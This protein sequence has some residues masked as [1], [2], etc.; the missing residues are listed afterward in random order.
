MAD[1][2]GMDLTRVFRPIL[3]RVTVGN[4][5]DSLSS[6]AEL[7]DPTHFLTDEL[8][9][10]KKGGGHKWTGEPDGDD[11]EFEQVGY[12]IKSGEA[13][14]T[15]EVSA[16]EYSPLLRKLQDGV[17]PDVDGYKKLDF[18]GSSVLYPVLVHELGKGN[19]VR[20]REGY[21]TVMVAEDQFDKTDVTGWPITFDFTYTI[22]LGG[23]V[24]E[25]FFV[26][27]PVGG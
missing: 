14:S 23:H 9:L 8:G 12:A 13:V 3:T 24:H 21:A 4:P 5:G 10:T 6:K 19:L 18:G 1:A 16:A 27:T 22:S 11:I 25:A 2:N 15:L 7:M 20:R 26:V 17:A